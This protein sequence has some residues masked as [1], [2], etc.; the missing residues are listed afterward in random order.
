MFSAKSSPR[1]GTRGAC[2]NFKLAQTKRK[3]GSRLCGGQGKLGI[4]HQVHALTSGGGCQ[5]LGGEIA[6][7]IP[8]TKRTVK[9]G[10]ASVNGYNTDPR[11]G[12]SVIKVD[13]QPLT[14]KIWKFWIP[15]KR[16]VS[17]EVGRPVLIIWTSEAD[18]DSKGSY[19]PVRSPLWKVK[20]TRTNFPSGSSS[21]TANN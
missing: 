1:S 14:T 5:R 2:Q 10:P 17:T 11:T 20:D 6:I 7:G 4:S 9:C 19:Q 8:A 13:G 21:I 12:G 16:T 15:R 3:D 18:Q